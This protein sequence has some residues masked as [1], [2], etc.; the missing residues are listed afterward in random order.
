VLAQPAVSLALPGVKNADE[1]QQ[2]LRTLEAPAEERDF[3]AVLPLFRDGLE[4]ICVY[5]NHCLPCPSGIDVGR[6]LRAL[7]GAR[8]GS[9]AAL[10]ELRGL[11]P[12]PDDCIRCGACTSRCPF[13][14]E[15]IAQMSEASER[16]GA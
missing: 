15:V 1:L 8:G 11:S 3:S 6:T 7:A 14:V 12:G 2:A 10:Q 5:C 13:G 9:T 4:G 16:M